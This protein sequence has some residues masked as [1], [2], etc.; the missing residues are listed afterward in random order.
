[1]KRIYSNITGFFSVAYF[2]SFV[3][4]IVDSLFLGSVTGMMFAYVGI[5]AACLS[6]VFSKLQHH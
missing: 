2:I 4:F 5:I 1:M 6:F 3:V